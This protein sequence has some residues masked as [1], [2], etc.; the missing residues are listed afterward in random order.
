MYWPHEEPSTFCLCISNSEYLDVY[1]VLK[2]HHVVS[3]Q[4]SSPVTPVLLSR[5]WRSTLFTWVPPA[6][7][8]RA[9]EERK[10]KPSL[11]PL[12]IISRSTEG[13]MQIKGASSSPPQS[14]SVGWDTAFWSYLPPCQWLFSAPPWRA[15]GPSPSLQPAPGSGGPWTGTAAPEP[16]QWEKNRVRVSPNTQFCSVQSAAQAWV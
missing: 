5:N 12:F 6:E 16:R 14:S 4:Q 1:V 11:Q 3:M 10:D 7:A 2:C 13:R 15:L 9:S 8:L